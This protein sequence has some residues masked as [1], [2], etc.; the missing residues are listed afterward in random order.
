[1]VSNILK[2]AI[3][4]CAV[5]NL[6]VANPTMHEEAEIPTEENVEIPA[7]TPEETPEVTPEETPEETP[8]VTFEE[9]VYTLIID[10][11]EITVTLKSETECE[12]SMLDGE[13]VKTVAGTYVIN[14]KGRLVL[15]VEGIEKDAEFT[16]EEDG[17]LVQYIYPCVITYEESKYGELLIDVQK[18]EPGEIVTIYAGAYPFF[19]VETVTANGVILTPGTDKTYKFQL[20]EGENVVT[21]T[22][23][24]N[25]AEIGELLAIIKQFEENN[26]ENFFSLETLGMLV[27]WLVTLVSSGALGV[28]FIKSKKI[29]AK[30]EDNVMETVLATL[31]D[32]NTKSIN[33]FLQNT[34]GPAFEKI[35]A[36]LEVTDKTCTTLARC[37]ILSQENTPEARLAI[38]SELTNLQKTERTLADEVKAII[39]KEV[40]ANKQ[41][42]EAK[43]ATLEALKEANESITTSQEQQSEGRY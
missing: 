32:V 43:A 27:S 9:K 33:Q 28:L 15:D 40:A 3:G 29:K 19:A 22:F 36:N 26:W 34:F 5:F 23:V 2:L 1:M 11:T 41:A 16:I 6:S 10:E 12:V 20:I 13:E 14:K 31:E 7:E 39:E 25:N 38:I 18:G 37:F 42:Q 21:A 17:T 35:S 24:I 30:T 8:E 4:L